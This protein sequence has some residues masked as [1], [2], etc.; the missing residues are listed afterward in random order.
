MDVILELCQYFSSVSVVL[1]MKKEKK[2][3]GKFLMVLPQDF[4]FGLQ[5]LKADRPEYQVLCNN[6]PALQSRGLLR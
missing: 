4:M 3:G 5:L 2:K 1:S 6:I